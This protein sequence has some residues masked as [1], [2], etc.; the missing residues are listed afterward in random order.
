VPPSHPARD[1][2]ARGL[3]L[4]SVWLAI[5][6]VAI[7]ASYLGLPGAGG[8]SQNQVYL[9]SLAAIT[10]V[11]LAFVV[12]SWLIARLLL[13][14]VGRW[15]PAAHTVPLAFVVFSA[16]SCVYFVANVVMLD[17]FG[18]FLTYQLLSLVGSVRMLRSSLSAY[19]TLP[20]VV[21]LVGVPLAYIALVWISA[22]R[23]G[24]RTLG[25]EAQGGHRH[26][27]P[28]G[29]HY[30]PAGSRAIAAALAVA[31]IA[32]G[33]H[34][35]STGWA[36]RQDRAI[37]ESPQWVFISSW[38]RSVNDGAG[39]GLADSFDSADLTDFEPRAARAVATPARAVRRVS[40]TL[41]P[42]PQRPLNVILIVLESVGERWTSL[43][44]AYNTTPTLAAESAHGLVFDNFYAHIGRSSN[45]LVSMLLS[46]Y[47]K[48]DFRDI[49]DQYPHLPGTSLA[50]V[51]EDRGY[52]T[53]FMTPS[54]LSWAGWT[55]FLQGRGFRDIADYHQLPCATPI[56]SWGVEDRCMVDGIIDYIGR[57]PGR[58]FFVMGWTQQTHHP[59]EP[60]PGIPLLDLV[61]EH[62][63][64]DYD[65]NR[66]LNVLR[67]TDHH[68]GRL[69]DA[70][71][72]A[73]LDDHTMVVIVG[74]HGQ[75]FGYPHEGNYMQGR[76]IYEE[77][78]HVPLLFWYPPL[79]AAGTRS[80]VI[81]GHVDLAP[82]IARVA[83]FGD[84]GD[85][86]GRS[87]IDADHFPRA[88]FYVAED[89]FRLGVRE[90]QWKYIYDLREA[91]E[92]LYDLDRDP[93]EQRNVAK[94][95]PQRS[96]R[97][98][99]RLAAWTEANRRQYQE[100]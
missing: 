83:G 71:R 55:S 22:R 90:H 42:S 77:D 82:T 4:A 3:F 40:M 78:V 68:L 73:A 39:I 63:P 54:D 64:D 35:Y 36:T 27:P 34:A 33:S 20:V 51:F 18:G 37:A 12:A 21:G 9:A 99:Q 80:P 65:L 52:R 50:S 86:Q 62:G 58:P 87:L 17:S 85:W 1:A 47:P 31:W 7:K 100:H 32:L 69:F 16:L 8:R 96:A 74:D 66:Y 13:G 59:Y 48:L 76:T 24:P 38:W 11:D 94:L 81:G 97:L 61:R 88:Y 98:R 41:P 30:V 70:I 10:Y 26:G 75:A 84:A 5:A 93:T 67:E 53:A 14:I 89:H 49:T 29:G 56:S 23:N 43:H 15:R 28:E 79:K 46:A 45:S 95:E 19:I 57:E 91:A 60:T 72:R 25:A 44:S 2:A 92:E 6:F